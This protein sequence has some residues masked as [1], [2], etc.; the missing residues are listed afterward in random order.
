MRNNQCRC[1]CPAHFVK[2]FSVITLAVTFVSCVLAPKEELAAPENLRAE[3][4]TDSSALICWDKV[5]HSDSYLVDVE[6][7]SDKTSVLYQWTKETNF[8]LENLIWE[9]SYNVTVYASTSAKGAFWNKY[10]DSKP[11]TFIFKTSPR[12]F[13]EVPAGEIGYVTN[14]TAVQN[15]DKS[16]TF[17]WEKIEGA[18]FYD[19]ICEHFMKGAID[20]VV[21]YNFITLNASV[22]NYVDT[23]VGEAYK[24]RYS[25]CGRDATFSNEGRWNETKKILVE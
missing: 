16:F 19:I 4:V 11:T 10:E 9:E 23:K 15:P 18:V 5:E 17:S 7:I 24:V 25:I 1:V 6:C 13:P 21:E 8:L 14:I 20:D 3:N 2:F 12:K 22:Q